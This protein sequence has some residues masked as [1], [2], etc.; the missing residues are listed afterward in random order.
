MTADPPGGAARH[1]RRVAAR[2][3]PDHLTDGQLLDRFRTGRDEWAF[4][5]LVS[6]HGPMVHAACRRVLRNHPDA[7]DAFQA[8]FLVLVRKAGDLSDRATV[9]DWL[10]GVAVRTALKARVTMARRRAHERTA[11]ETR[12][13]AAS[14]AEPADWLDRE[15][16]RLPARYREPVV[17]C[18]IEERPREEVALALGIPEGTLASRLATARKRLADALTRRGVG[19]AALAAGP[20]PAGLAD[21][22]VA[23]IAA[24]SIPAAAD[25]LAA[26]VLRAMV[27]SKLGLGLV[28]TATV[29][30]VGALLAAGHAPLAPAVPSPADPPPEPAWKAEFR[31]AY[32]LADGQ[33]VKRVA[34]PFPAS[35]D[36]YFRAMHKNPEAPG[37]AERA[38]E[39]AG[40]SALILWWDGKAIRP[41]SVLES[42]TP[43]FALASHLA[44]HLALPVEFGGADPSPITGDFVLRAGAA[45]EKLLPAVEKLL[46]DECGVKVALAVREVEREVIVATGTFKLKPRPWRK[47]N[48]VDVYTGDKALDKDLKPDGQWLRGR[49]GLPAFARDLERFTGKRVVNET[50]G[51]APA[52]F[53]WYTHDRNSG[54]LAEQAEDHDLE[55]VLANVSEQTGLTFKTEMRTVRVLS[56]KK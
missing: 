28:L 16:A 47:A 54:D 44:D 2:L 17:L 6:R 51:P 46:R 11:A 23:R 9:G 50:V 10:Y 4:A 41:A 43:T 29:V 3:D 27:Y 36:D 40:R 34:P 53:T 1:L 30:T 12:P 35:R 5:Q 37:T 49:G 56:A 26:E 7:D 8:A 19:V 33:L 18:L 45:P 39:H 15:L 14:P 52:A 20:V 32:A 48:E 38:K 31:K 55:K 42:P 21:E 24:G 13:L 22:T 25:Q